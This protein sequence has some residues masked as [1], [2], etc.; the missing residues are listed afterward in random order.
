NNRSVDEEDKG[1]FVQVDFA[2]EIASMPFR[3]NFGVRYVQTQQS[4]SGYTFVSGSAVPITVGRHYDDTLPSM[5]LVLEPFE[6]FLVR[7]GAAQTMSRPDLGN[8]TPG[9][10]ISVSGANRTVTAGNPNLDPF[11]AKAYDL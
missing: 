6:G 7:F 9:A 3:G 2:T 4:A 5:N 1:G 11:R 10:T 8:L